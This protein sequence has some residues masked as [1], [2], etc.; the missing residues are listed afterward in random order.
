MELNTN[1]ALLQACRRTQS[2]QALLHT[3]N[4][5]SAG[6]CS[7]SWSARME[8]SAAAHTSAVLCTMRSHSLL[9][10]PVPAGEVGELF[11]Q[12]LGQ[13]TAHHLA[14]C[15]SSPT[16]GWTHL[17]MQGGMGGAWAAEACGDMRTCALCVARAA[18]PCRSNCSTE[19][20]RAG[21]C[22]YPSAP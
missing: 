22:T 16:A 1:H 12:L 20:K 17:C 19:G 4:V 11:G 14:L 21:A 18:L 5:D 13:L 10:A 6:A 2:P 8:D 7:S 3:S 15:L 9:N